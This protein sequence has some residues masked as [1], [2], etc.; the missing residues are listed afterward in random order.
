LRKFFLT[1]LLVLASAAAAADTVRQPVFLICP[2]EH[3]MS[4]WSA[5]LVCDK[6]DPSKV[7]SLGLEK[8]KRKNAQ[9][10]DVSEVRKAQLEADPVREQMGSI[11]EKDFKAGV[12]AVKKDDALFMSVTPL[13]NDE[14][15]LNIDMRV[16]ADKRY[17]IGGKDK[18]KRDIVLRY[19]RKTNKWSTF[20]K[21]LT[22][23]STTDTN[24]KD[25]GSDTAAIWGI[26][27]PVVQQSGIYQIA[28]VLDDGGFIKVFERE[29]KKPED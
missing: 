7:V 20:A 14:Y 8:L 1:L 9:D 18:D 16:A 2:K 24:G 21:K 5:Y 23:I 10:M 29:D 11:E 19:D 15:Q 12:I 25:V 13:P 22:V 4:A 3:G 6:S 17:V 26:V 28:M 27:F